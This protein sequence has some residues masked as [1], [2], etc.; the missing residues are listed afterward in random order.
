[1][2]NNESKV[3]IKE[4]RSDFEFDDYIVVVRY[5]ASFDEDS[6]DWKTKVKRITNQGVRQG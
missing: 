4:L 5:H 3:A 2:Q 6:E 1:M